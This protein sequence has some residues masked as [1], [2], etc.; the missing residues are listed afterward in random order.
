MIK[1]MP[2]SLRR[3]KEQ[4]KPIP[5][6]TAYDF[7]TAKLAERAGIPLI[8]VGDSMGMAVLGYETTHQVVL[9]DIIRASA[10]VSRGA[11]KTLVI[12]D[13]PFM[14]YQASESEA[15][16][17]AGRLVREGSAEAVKVEGGR[18]IAKTILR[19]TEAGIPVMGHVGFTPQSLYNLGGYRI[20]GKTTSAADDIVEDAVSVEK[21]GAFAIVA[22]LVTDSVAVRLTEAVSVPIIGIGAGT[23][24]DGQV[25]VVTD[26]LGM[27]PDFRPKHGVPYANLALTI[28][29]AFREYAEDVSSY[30]F[31]ERL[32]DKGAGTGEQKIPSQVNENSRYG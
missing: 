4:G 3:M 1:T 21:A 5:M 8:L 30:R 18:P 31:S 27:D 11:P 2:H 23:H 6:V 28:E 9:D 29:K 22:E 7:L 15:V 26:L 13:M 14:S 16:S 20:Q 24:V 19:I 10:A 12:A 32:L 17:N 25:Q